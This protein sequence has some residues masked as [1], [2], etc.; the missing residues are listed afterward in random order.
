MKTNCNHLLGHLHDYD[1]IPLRSLTIKE[2]LLLHSESSIRMQKEGH[3]KKGCKPLDY[4][5]KRQSMSE[6]FN[7]CP[8][9]G[10]KI[11]WKAIK[12]EVKGEIGKKYCLLLYWY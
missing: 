4:L 11:D 10:D 1:Y 8:F 7:Y 2:D 12:K 6:M 5:D 9:C 3:S